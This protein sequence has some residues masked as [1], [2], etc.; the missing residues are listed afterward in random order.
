VS[1]G[2]AQEREGL[3]DELWQ[4]GWRRDM[5]RKGRKLRDEY[6]SLAGLCARAV[7]IVYNQ[8]TI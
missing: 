8:G 6:L 5:L 7:A 3:K 2:V 4:R 1:V